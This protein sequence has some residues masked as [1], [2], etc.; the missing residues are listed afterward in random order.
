MKS[1]Q[2]QKSDTPKNMTAVMILLLSITGLVTGRN[3]SPFPA[4]NQ[5]NT[6]PSANHVQLGLASYYAKKYQGKTTASGEI[7]DMNKLTAAHRT[8]PFGTV[9][10]VTRLGN[11]QS[12]DV[13]I[14][15]RGP[16]I[17][18]R[19][20]DLSLAAARKLDMVKAGVVEVKVEVLNGRQATND[21]G[22]HSPTQPLVLSSHSAA[23]RDW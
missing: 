10:R 1:V 4:P 6:S 14:N 9:V 7:F 18:G 21:S 15:D 20:I 13:R 3:S 8:Y 16:F 19:I 12:V 22:S 5:T 11:G 2:N 23:D 17:S